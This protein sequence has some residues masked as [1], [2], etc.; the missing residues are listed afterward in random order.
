MAKSKIT[1]HIDLDENNVPEKLNWESTD[2]MKSGECKAAFLSLWDSEE[3]NTLKIDLWTKDMLVE[4]MKLFYFQTFS[5]MA[6]TYARASGD[7]KMADQMKQ[8]ARWY[9]EEEGFVEKEAEN[10]KG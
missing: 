3:K 2:R 1:L 5:T 7:A 10:E 6:D 4:D 8:F 9:G